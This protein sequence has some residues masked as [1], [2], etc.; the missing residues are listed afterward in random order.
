MNKF[1]KRFVFILYVFFSIISFGSAVSTAKMLPGL[2]ADLSQTS[3][4]GLSSGAFMSVQFHV[5]YS[6]I[7]VGAG[8]VAGG[9]Y[10]CAGCYEVNTFIQNAVSTCMKPVGGMAPDSEILFEKAQKFQE[11]GWIDSLINLTDDRVYVFSGANDKTVYPVVV[12][13]TEKFYKL[14]GLDG[15]NIKF[16]KYIYAGHAMCTDNNDD[17]KCPETKPPYINDCDFIQ[18]HDILGHIFPDLKPP[19]DKLNGKIVKF[20]QSEFFSSKDDFDR[21]SMSSNGYLYVPD[22]CRNKKCKVHVVFHGCEQGYEVIGDEYYTSLGYNEMADANN[23]L[24]LYPQV[25]PSK[26]NPY[27]PKGCWDWWGYSS[28]DPDNPDFYTKNGLQMSAV[29]KMLK[30]LAAPARSSSKTSVQQIYSKQ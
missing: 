23:M 12:E 17:V 6:R 20:D 15:D 11:K 7:M 22:L 13:Q 25:K 5:A 30:R 24:V 4:S 16:Q 8:I 28:K 18:S 2:G 21:A 9:P 27:N 26:M 29:M 14:A 10:Y 19:S 1:I 3:V